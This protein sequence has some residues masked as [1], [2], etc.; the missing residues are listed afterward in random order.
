M[1]PLVLKLLTLVAAHDAVVSQK[2]ALRAT[3]IA[4]TEKFSRKLVACNTFPDEES[5]SITRNRKQKVET[6]LR[7]KQCKTLKS[8]VEEGDQFV[9]ESRSAG[10]WTFQVGALPETD[11]SLLL[12][13]EK[14]DAT[15][16]VPSFQSFSFPPSKT[17]S[18][19]AIIDTYKGDKSRTRVHVKDSAAGHK[20]RAEDLDY[21]RV[22]ALESG[23][24]DLSM[25]LST[26]A[27][28]TEA[29]A[30]L[31]MNKG[32]DYVVLRT[33][34][35]GYSHA[36]SEELVAVSLVESSASAVLCTALF[37]YFL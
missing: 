15:S 6:D 2:H 34:G 8:E 26:G 36:Y 35:Q 7:Y 14:R 1:A 25:L 12:V 30:H 37:A 28:S 4:H 31:H 16:K 9:F 24:Y 3:P 27:N 21:D 22:Y 17:D 13:F 33:G 29:P 20:D 11:S 23:D 19:L 5:V 10:T 18:Q 32:G